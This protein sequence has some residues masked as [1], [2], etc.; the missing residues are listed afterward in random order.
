MSDSCR[1]SCP[2]EANRRLPRWSLPSRGHDVAKSAL[3]PEGAVLSSVA[4]VAVLIPAYN[5]EASLL[6]QVEHLR[7][8]GFQS[9]IVVN[10]GSDPQSDPVF[11]DLSGIPGCEVLHHAVNLGKGRALKTGL[12][13]FWLTRPGYRGVVTADC[14]GQHR[15]EDIALVAQALVRSPGK[16]ILGVRRFSGRVP[17]RSL[18]GNLLTRWLFR[19]LV[20]R[21]L[22]DTQS[23]LRGIPREAIPALLRLEGERYEYEMN[24]LVSAQAGALAIV[25]Q[26][27]ETVYADGN[28]S[29][30]FHPLLDSMKIYFVL[31]RFYL[32]SLT[33]SSLDLVFFTLSY[34]LTS[35]ILASLLIGRLIFGCLL[36]FGMNRLFVFR[37]RRAIAGPL[38]KYYLLVAFMAAVSYFS[39]RALSQ[40]LGLSVILC[41]VL[42]ETPLSVINF[43]IQRTFVF[44]GSAEEPA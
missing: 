8:L 42:V 14:D 3:A 20:G 31:F 25:E 2:G 34:K 32:S 17:F 10:D 26:P 12:N 15:P 38:A 5:P 40:N 19:L 22:T 1:S 6:D 18:V 30:H 29:S 27:V 11:R 41:K 36:N 21:R 24:M 9:T 7:R 37:H 4:E 33:A 28:R 35:N 16:L 44:S 23:G 43:A 13:H 39:I